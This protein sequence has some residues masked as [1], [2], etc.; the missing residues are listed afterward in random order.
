MFV[1]VT[2]PNIFGGTETMDYLQQFFFF[3][4]TRPYNLLITQL[5]YICYDTNEWERERERGTK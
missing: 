5:H 3:E 4:R 2:S 1:R